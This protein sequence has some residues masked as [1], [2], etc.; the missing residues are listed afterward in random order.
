MLFYTNWDQS[1]RYV[2]Q[3]KEATQFLC[4][5]DF[6]LLQI[7]SS[8]HPALY[9]MGTGGDSLGVK[10]PK[11]ESDNSPPSSTEVKNGGAIPP[12]LYISL[13][14]RVSLNNYRDSYNFVCLWFI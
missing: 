5:R 1:M 11:R 4:G 7:G 9:P 14:L 12:L 10:R 13:W 2:N 6:P 8:I 3:I